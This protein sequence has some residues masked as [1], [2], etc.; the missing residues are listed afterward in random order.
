MFSQTFPSRLPTSQAC[1]LGFREDEGEHVSRSAATQGRVSASVLGGLSAGQRRERGA[2]N[3]GPT[4]EPVG[5]KKPVEGRAGSG[6][7]PAAGAARRP[8]PG[9]PPSPQPR[10]RGAGEAALDRASRCL[11]GPWRPVPGRGQPQGCGVR[12]EAPFYATRAFKSRLSAFLACDR[13]RS[14]LFKACSATPPVNVRCEKMAAAQPEG[15]FSPGRP[16]PPRPARPP[17]WQGHV[18]PPSGEAGKT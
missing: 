15:L 12:A 2:P 3:A 8:E 10:P 5:P 11:Q 18:R 9:Q 7:R 16:A 4:W 6:A 1:R 17:I 14:H 13:Q